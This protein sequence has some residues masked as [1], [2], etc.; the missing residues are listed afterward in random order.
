MATENTFVV[1]SENDVVSPARDDVVEVVEDNNTNEQVVK[2]EN[3]VVKEQVDRE[4][5][6][7]YT[8]QCKW[9]NDKLGFGFIT[10]C[11][12]N[13]KGRDIFVHHSGIKPL[14]SNYRTLKKGEYINFNVV[15]GLNGL[16]AVDVTGIHG[17]PL[18]CDHVS[19]G[20]RLGSPPG[21]GQVVMNTPVP[22]VPVKYMNRDREWQTVGKKPRAPPNVSSPSQTV[23]KYDKNKRYP[24]NNRPYK[25]S[26]STA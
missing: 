8:G 13:D 2:D 3:V 26:N 14:N 24:P 22:V 6:G 15:D 11:E 7:T 4:S 9:F 19:N 5:C 18:M 16:Q 10:I 23:S 17:G 12:G 21:I 20:K 25:R 1:L